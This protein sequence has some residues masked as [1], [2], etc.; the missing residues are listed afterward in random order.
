MTYFKNAGWKSDWIDTARDI[1]REE[2]EK[3][4]KP[5][6]DRSFLEE[7]TTTTEANSV[8]LFILFSRCAVS[9]F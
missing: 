1:L 7:P 5:L 2:W 9:D 6:I 4:Y 3:Y 8:S